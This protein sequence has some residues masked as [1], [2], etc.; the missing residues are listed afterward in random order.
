MKPT[1]L[2]CMI[3]LAFVSF[4]CK[5][6]VDIISTPSPAGKMVISFARVPASITHVVATLSRE[7]FSN[8][9]LSLTIADSGQD[10][11]GTFQEVSSGVWHLKV[12]AMDE[13]NVVRF[14]GETDVDIIPGETVRA[15]LVLQPAT[16]SLEIHVTWG[17]GSSNADTTSGPT[18]YF[19][20]DGN[21]LD[22]S[23]HNNNGYAQNQSYTTDPW[24]NPN[25]AYF[26]NGVNNYVTV[27]DTYSLNPQNQLS[28]AMW[29]RIDSVTNN[30]ALV[31]S[32]GAPQ[33]DGFSNREYLLTWK[34]NF[35]CPYL[36]LYSAGDGGGQN[37][38]IEDTP[39]HTPGVWIYVTAVIDRRAHRMQLYINGTLKQEVF[40]GYSSFNISSHPLLIGWTEEVAADY[41]MFLGA[42]DNL[43]IYTRALTPTQIQTLYNSHQGGEND[44]RGEAR[45]EAGENGRG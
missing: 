44:L 7:G 38:L 13:S 40:D 8:Q 26:F 20:F 30:Y 3:A 16:G 17:G 19:Q 33:A 6:S 10:A 24:G 41:G 1:L 21:T 42:M 32:K 43:R 9:V 15:D 39:C 4:N 28:I 18:L 29:I 11:S 36:Q 14:T 25:S 2:L 12:D 45:R 22:S 27:P 35:A 23:G 5:Q 37:E 34:A 31:I